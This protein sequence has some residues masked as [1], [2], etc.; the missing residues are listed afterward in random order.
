MTQSQIAH[1]VGT[2]QTSI[3]AYERGAYSPNRERLVQLI[4]VLGLA[5]DPDDWQP[6]D[7]EG[8]I[9]VAQS[10]V[11]NYER[12][13]YRPDRRRLESL[14]EL[15]GLEIAP[16]DW[17]VADTK[18]CP[19]GGWAGVI[20]LVDGCQRPVDSLGLCS[21][22]YISQ[23]GARNLAAG[24]VCTVQGCGQGEYSGGL[25]LRC[26]DRKRRGARPINEVRAQRAAAGRERE[27]RSRRS[28]ALKPR[29]SNR[30]AQGIR[31]RW[32]AGNADVH[33]LALEHCLSDLYV[34]LVLRRLLFDGVPFVAGERALDPD[35]KLATARSVGSS[36][37]PAS[38]SGPRSVPPPS[39]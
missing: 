27:A 36:P 9:G 6:R 26:W 18:R 23:R 30:M 25:C 10:D 4:E 15:L 16:E 22:H 37:T 19:N 29:M 21:L 13:R 32:W 7:G 24:R 1:L 39:G 11:S 31:R 35:E 28:T 8:R 20:C 2:F 12:G 34:E 5:I 3:S 38:A 14:V 17:R 33:E